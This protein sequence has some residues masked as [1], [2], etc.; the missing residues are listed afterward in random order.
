MI[1]IPGLEITY[2]FSARRKTIGLMVTAEGK[3]V[4]AA[5]RGTSQ[6]KIAQAV[7]KHQTWIERKA[8][9]RK[10]AWAPLKDGV[11]FFR[12][13][14]FRLTVLPGAEDSVELGASEITV[15]LT[16]GSSALWP[17]L[18]SWYLR[19]AEKVIR[20]RVRHY[21][22]VMGLDPGQTQLRNWRRRWGECH[23]KGVLRFNWRLIMLPLDM[24]DYVV[25]HE[26]AHLR[27]GGH[28]ARFWQ[29]VGKVL[30]DYARRRRWLNQSG[31][32]FLTWQV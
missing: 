12:G 32:P 5:P 27:E 20:E 26:L 25:V 6:A 24:L 22:R 21:G 11:A 28:T 18:Q 10:E 8:A 9:A 15:R 30:P 3:L 14:P 29:E 7:A 23:P 17:L 31:A 19:E 2:K 16:G 1:K 4:I 13:Q